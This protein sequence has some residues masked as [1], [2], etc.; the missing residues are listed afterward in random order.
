MRMLRL[1]FEFENISKIDTVIATTYSTMEQTMASIQISES[2]DNYN[3]TVSQYLPKREAK[4]VPSFKS[5][6]ARTLEV[7]MD[8]FNELCST[9]KISS[10]APKLLRQILNAIPF[11]KIDHGVG[12]EF[13]HSED[14][15]K[16]ASVER[17]GHEDG[18][19]ILE[20]HGLSWKRLYYERLLCELL[21][22]GDMDGDMNGENITNVELL[23]VVSEK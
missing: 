23:G 4:A 10:I 19:C 15:Y 12:A 2:S 8:N 17:Y 14:F 18:K 6:S 13:V 9:K 7:V 21:G 11:D 22:G 3:D 5:L 20:C 1:L 16:R